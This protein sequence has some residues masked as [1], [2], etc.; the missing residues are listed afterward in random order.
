M[1][2]CL[3]ALRTSTAQ[4]VVSQGRGVRACRTQPARPKNPPPTRENA[5]LGQIEFP[6]C[7]LWARGRTSGPDTPKSGRL[8]QDFPIWAREKRVAR[9]DFEPARTRSGPGAPR[10]P[11]PDLLLAQIA[12]FWSRS[13]IDPDQRKSDPDQRKSDLAQRKSDLAQ[14]KSDLG[15]MQ[16]SSGPDD[17]VHYGPDFWGTSTRSGPRARP[18]PLSG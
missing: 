7:D 14:R 15:Q 11:E 1:I 4:R 17:L 8:H 3:S 18:E 13:K 6:I 12:F 2:R 10:W 16:N 9:P 5:A